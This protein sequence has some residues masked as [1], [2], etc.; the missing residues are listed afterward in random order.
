MAANILFILSDQHSYKI[1]GYAGNRIVRTPNLDRL[2]ARGTVMRDCYAACPLCVPSRLSMLSGQYASSVRA[3]TNTVSLDS[4]TATFVHSL[5]ANG[6][7]TTLCGRMHF[8]GPDQ[9]HGFTRRLVGDITPT[10]YRRRQRTGVDALSWNRGRIEHLA[11]QCMGGGNSTVLEYDRDV[12][13]AA[14]EYL[15]GTFEQPQFLCV[16]MYAPHFPYIAPPDLFDYYYDRVIIPEASFGGDEHPVFRGKLRDTDPET[17]RAAMAAYYGMVEF[18][19]QNIGRILEA[20]DAYLTR[21]G[22]EGIVIYASDHG[23]MN[24]EHGFY[25]KNTFF[26]A[27]VHVPMIFAGTGIPEGKEICTPVSLLDLSPTVCEMAGAAHPPRQDGK[28]IREL[29]CKDAVDE[30]RVVVSELVNRFGV[31]S[32]GRMAKWKQYK[33]ITFSG[34]DGQ[35]QLFD[36]EADPFETGNLIS[37]YPWVAEKLSGVLDKMKAPQT[38]MAELDEQEANLVQI[39]GCREDAP[40]EWTCREG[41]AEDAPVPMI[42]TKKEIS[43]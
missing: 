40:E 2:A 3:L 42:S 14:E 15:R 28:S 1:Q 5:N 32:M 6:Y 26:D 39:S 13:E 12:A 10:S 4:N 37:A 33:Y 7:D 22:E 29:I 16:G 11:I 9:R 21:T 17:V 36:M 30:E 25:G 24:G 8:L 34:F 35:D 27:A 20:W 23:D 38:V 18:M 43:F 31:K 41:L 19:D